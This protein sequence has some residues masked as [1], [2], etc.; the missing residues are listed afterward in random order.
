MKGRV[1]RLP[2]C[3]MSEYAHCSTET[4]KIVLHEDRLIHFLD[5]KG[6]HKCSAWEFGKGSSCRICD[7]DDLCAGLWEMGTYHSAE[8]LLPVTGSARAVARRV[9]NS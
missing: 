5:E 1:E 4:R 8:E 2:L 3:Y 6:K 7:L 9:L